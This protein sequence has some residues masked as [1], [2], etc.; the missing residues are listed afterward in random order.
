MKHKTLRAN[1]L[2]L[3]AAVF[4][5]S[6]FAAQRMS[7]DILPPFAFQGIRC[8]LGALV[9]L[10]V[11]ALFDRFGQKGSWK[12][13]K[14]WFGGIACGLVLF[15]STNLQQ[16]GLSLGTT[17]GKS[18]FI[19]AMYII[20]VP[21]LSLFSGKKI[22]RWVWLSVLLS[23]CGLYLL[24]MKESFRLS[25][26]DAL[27]LGCAFCFALHILVV[28]L[29]SGDVD[30]IRL[31]CIQFLVCGILSAAAMSV[32]EI[33]TWQNVA[34]C[35][36]PLA[37]AAVLSSAVAYTF[38]IIGQR[39]TNPAVAAVIM[40]MESVFACLSGWLVLHEQLSLREGAGCAIMF[41]AVLL[42][43]KPGKK[44]PSA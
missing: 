6:T 27:T 21:I 8:T 41:C 14:L 2:L 4:W 12:I 9:L 18:G 5:G 35:W 37:Y 43:Q 3:L 13:K 28:D 29:V 39:D 24:C 22:G 17:A 23:V 34:D 38:Q 1:I 11:I 15:L 44:H 10:P 32:T 26:G 31:S 36:F 30:P 7:V 33:P 42:A 25:V 20:I 19:T 16:Y 40:S